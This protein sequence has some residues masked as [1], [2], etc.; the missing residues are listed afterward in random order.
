VRLAAAAGAA[1]FWHLAV[2]HADNARLETEAAYLREEYA[3]VIRE[4]E[5]M[6]ESQEAGERDWWWYVLGMSHLQ[7]RQI[8][9]AKR[10]FG[11]MIERFPESRWRPDAGVALAD[12]VWVSGDPAGAVALYQA[13]LERWGADH[14]ILPRAQY[15]R[16]QAARAAG[17]WEVAKAALEAVVQDYPNSFEAGLARRFLEEAEFA[18]FVQVGAFGVR[19]NAVRLQR[20]LAR[21]GYA[22]GVHATVADGRPIHRVRVGRFV[23]R[24]KAQEVARQLQEA[25]FPTRIVP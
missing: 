13:V 20:E 10:A 24:E 5:R 3:A 4:A 25:G 9:E 8:P 15:Q 23:N 14:P 17:Q 19:D 18:F 22:A 12:A 21:R 11:E 1:V 7:L 16:G 6:T 2:A